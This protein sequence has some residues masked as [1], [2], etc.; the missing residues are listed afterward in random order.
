MLRGVPLS[1]SDERMNVSHSCPRVNIQHPTRNFQSGGKV[2]GI[3]FKLVSQPTF[4]A[5]ALRLLTA[6]GCRGRLL[7]RW[8][9]FNAD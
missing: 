7:H 1:M 5:T 4:A 2:E 6:Y 8:V 3:E 9:F